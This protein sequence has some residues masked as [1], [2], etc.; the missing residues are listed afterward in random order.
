MKR[1]TEA[2]VKSAQQVKEREDEANVQVNK[3]MVGG[4]AQVIHNIECLFPLRLFIFY[5]PE[6]PLNIACCGSAQ[7]PKLVMSDC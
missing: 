2:L 6:D 7:T 3:R 5:L 4:V 1:A